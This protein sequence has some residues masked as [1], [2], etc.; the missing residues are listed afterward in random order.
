ML[1]V[2]DA[3]KYFDKNADFVITGNPVRQE[4]LTAKKKK[5]QEKNSGLTTVP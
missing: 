3:K 2:P 1:A 5:S 4:I